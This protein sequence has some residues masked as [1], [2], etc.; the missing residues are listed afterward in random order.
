VIAPGPIESWNAPV[1]APRI[2]KVRQRMTPAER[3]EIQRKWRLANLDKVCEAQ[4]KWRLANLDK[5]R[6]AQRKWRLANLD[7]VRNYRLAN[8][9]AGR[10]YHRKWRLANPDKERERVRKWRLAN[11]DRVRELQ[12]KWCLV[13]RYGPE[14]GLKIMQL[15]E[16][17]KVLKRNAA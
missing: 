7:K 9:D 5:V 8:L 15:R 10:E 11:L 12:R 6:E 2:G 17:L 1:K 3:K 16:L 4:R 14:R 13:Q